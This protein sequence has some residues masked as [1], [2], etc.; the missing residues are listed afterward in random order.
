MHVYICV[1]DEHANM[2]NKE[3]DREIQ[4]GAVLASQKM[5]L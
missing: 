1:F 2:R 3:R 4:R 5:P